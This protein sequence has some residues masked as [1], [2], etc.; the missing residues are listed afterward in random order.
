MLYDVLLV[1]GLLVHAEHET[2]MPLVAAT[3]VDVKK[4][5][6]RLFKNVNVTRIENVCKR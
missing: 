3:V 1:V 4:R 6:K 2:E 5:S